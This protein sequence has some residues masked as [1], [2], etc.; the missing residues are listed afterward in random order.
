MET[1]VYFVAAAL[2][3][4]VAFVV[5]RVLVR[6]DYRRKRR[7]TLLSSLLE[8]LVMCLYVSFPSLYNPPQWMSFWSRKVPVNEPLRTAGVVCIAIGM[9]SAFGTMFWFGLRR[10]FGVQV[11]GLVQSGPYRV[12]RNPQLVGFTPVVLGCLLL[13]PSWY[14]LGW[15]ALYGV[16]AHLMVVTEEEHLLAVSGEEYARYCRRVPRYVG[17]WWKGAAADGCSPCR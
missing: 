13:W 17:L 3:I 4:A 14:A 7:A 10:A 12:T 11:K 2:L 15:A 1:V 8:L 6:R 16:V 9:L 5:F